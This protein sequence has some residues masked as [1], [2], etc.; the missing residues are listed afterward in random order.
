MKDFQQIGFINSGHYRDMYKNNKLDMYVISNED[1][2]F[3]AQIE[4]SDQK[5]IAIPLPAGMNK[6][7]HT[8][9][10]HLLEFI[11]AKDNMA[12]TLDTMNDEYSFDLYFQQLKPNESTL[13]PT[14]R[15]NVLEDGEDI[16]KQLKKTFLGPFHIV[17]RDALMEEGTPTGI[18]NMSDLRGT[19][20]RLIHVVPHAPI[21][22]FPA[23]YM[24]LQNTSVA[25]T[26]DTPN[27]VASDLEFDVQES[28][29]VRVWYEVVPLN[30]AEKQFRAT[31]K[32]T[33]LES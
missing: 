8:I 12:L 16:Q 30:S 17:V 32:F 5:V 27:G 29:A 26:V 2:G 13:S 10:I 1:Q 3:D 33:T 22:L 15:L 7:T 28:L 21:R 6:D 9:E 18:L 19:G 25:Y 23:L 20:S 31:N 11:F 14:A 4:I 24:V